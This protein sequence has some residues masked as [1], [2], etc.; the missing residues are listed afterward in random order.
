MKLSV[1]LPAEDVQFLDEYAR[2]QGIESRSAALLRAVRLL[3][4]AGL[5]SAYEQ[6][7]DE[8]QRTG[9]ADVWEVTV[10]DGLAKK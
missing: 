2:K 5:G 8:W 4:G 3:K 1:S 6:A 9:E 10:A 7:W